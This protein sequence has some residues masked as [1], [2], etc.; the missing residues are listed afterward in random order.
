M[1]VVHAMNQELNALT[2]C[3]GW[4]K[5]EKQS[6][7]QIFNQ[8]PEQ[9]S[10]NERK[11]YGIER[12]FLLPQQCGDSRNINQKGRARVYPRKPVQPPILEQARRGGCLGW[13]AMQFVRNHGLMRLPPDTQPPSPLK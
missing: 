9:I 6:V 12:Q 11:H 1:F 3:A 8:C 2:D 4:S 7:S 13:R 10:G 5:V